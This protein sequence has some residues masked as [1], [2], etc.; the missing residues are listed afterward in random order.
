[1]KPRPAVTVGFEIHNL[2]DQRT[3][4]VELVPPGSPRPIPVLAA[5]A[6]FGGYPLPGRAFYGTVDLH[7]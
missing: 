2:F 6:D 7:L 1:V 4:Y 3:E 5:V